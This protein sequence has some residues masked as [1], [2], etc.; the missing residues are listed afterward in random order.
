MSTI[1]FA[2]S[3]A[4]I[5]HDFRSRRVSACVCARAAP[6]RQV[7]SGVRSSRRCQAAPDRHILVLWIDVDVGIRRRLESA[8]AMS[9]DRA[10]LFS[11]EDR[12]IALFSE[13]VA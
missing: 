13:S 10:A 2:A 12:P 11:G 8:R 3:V 7:W 6:S 5:A 4:G 1:R 9:G